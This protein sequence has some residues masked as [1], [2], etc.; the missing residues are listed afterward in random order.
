MVDPPP[1]APGPPAAARRLVFPRPDYWLEFVFWWLKGG[2]VEM[3]KCVSNGIKIKMNMAVLL[4]T[5]ILLQ[6]LLE[7]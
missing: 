6:W 2:G 4:V 1:A 7:F 5:A 3:K